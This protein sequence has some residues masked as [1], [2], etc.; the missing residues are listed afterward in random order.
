[1]SDRMPS[2][3]PIQTLENLDPGLATTPRPA[4]EVRRRGE[5]I[6]HRRL[7]AV[8]VAVAASVAALAAPFVLLDRSADE[9]PPISPTPSV[10]RA[11]DD[12]APPPVVG[13]DGFAGL[14]LGMSVEEVRATGDATLHEDVGGLCRTFT[15]TGDLPAAD[16]DSETD[17]FVSNEYGLVAVFARP[18]L[19]TPEGV[20]VG[21][22]LAELR[23]AYP[24][25]D[26]ATGWFRVPLGG[27]REYEFGIGPGD[28][29]ESLSI[30]LVEQD[31]FG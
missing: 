30:R 14:R 18:G 25:G 20:G 7:A 15:L 4:T 21:S 27:G 9:V 22:T 6:R 12:A 29:A 26:S 23:A 5:Q 17:G 10:T 31:C 2:F 11:P 13:P 16:A 19:S 8:G 1:M 28:T 3:D 24:A